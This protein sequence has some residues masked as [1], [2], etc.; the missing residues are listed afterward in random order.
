MIVRRYAPEESGIWANTPVWGTDNKLLK[1]NKK[2]GFSMED[3]K[4]DN[5]TEESEGFR[6]LGRCG[7]CDS[8]CVLTQ[9][10]SEAHAC[11]D[12]AD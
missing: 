6:C 10:H 8:P 9:G 11:H 3:K 5:M 12:H 2:E 7:V 1:Q 4:T